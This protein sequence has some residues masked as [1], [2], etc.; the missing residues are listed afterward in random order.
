MKNERRFCG[1]I[2]STEIIGS[3]FM[4]D[5]DVHI[6]SNIPHGSK[7]LRVQ[8]DIMYDG[9][10]FIVENKKFPIAK[11]GDPITIL[12][13]P[14]AI[15]IEHSINYGESIK[16]FFKKIYERFGKHNNSKLE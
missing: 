3:M 11:E 1:F 7:I 6:K 10:L 2:V 14:L 13:S 16:T 9:F 15:N 12:P 4:N 8:Y 5:S